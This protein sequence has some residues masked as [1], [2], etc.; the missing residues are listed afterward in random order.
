MSENARTGSSARARRPAIVV[1]S[2]KVT[3]ALPFSRITLAEPDKDL[4]EL[5]AIV[6]E[7]AVFAEVAA[8]GPQTTS[9]H[10]RA[11]ALAERLR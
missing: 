9:L 6:A 3:V 7:L 4:A 1:P 8:P 2:N 11:Q 5:A 10:R